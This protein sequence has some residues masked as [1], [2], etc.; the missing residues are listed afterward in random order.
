VDF[1]DAL[2]QLSLLPNSV[3]AH[4]VSRISGSLD[5]REFAESESLQVS[6]SLRMS[7][8][9]D[10]RKFGWE[11]VWM[12]GSLDEQ[13]FGWAE[14]CGWARAHV[15]CWWIRFRMAQPFRRSMRPEHL[16]VF[17][18]R[19]YDNK[20]VVL[21]SRKKSKKVGKKEHEGSR[22]VNKIYPHSPCLSF[23]CFCLTRGSYS[24]T[25]TPTHVHGRLFISSKPLLH[26]EMEKVTTQANISTY[27]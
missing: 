24:H 27:R 10:E 20:E 19:F 9:L 26:L 21:S 17:F 2:R 5:E 12:S 15:G 25:R 11:G 13:D 7:G 22:Q 3:V 23:S 8:S 4:R 6:E 1:L 16:N 14:V 18:V